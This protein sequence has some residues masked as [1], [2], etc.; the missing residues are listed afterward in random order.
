MTYSSAMRGALLDLHFSYDA[1][2]EIQGLAS[3]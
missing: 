3:H 1:E 2:Y